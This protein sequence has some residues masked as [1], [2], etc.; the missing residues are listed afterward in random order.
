MTTGYYKVSGTGI[1]KNW[2]SYRRTVGA[3]A[4]TTPTVKD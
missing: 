4:E 3:A 1:I 2:I